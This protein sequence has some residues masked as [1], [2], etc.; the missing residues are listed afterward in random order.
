M[1]YADRSDYQKELLNELYDRALGGTYYLLDHEGTLGLAA[2][3]LL[4][5]GFIER[6]T[7]SDQVVGDRTFAAIRLNTYGVQYMRL[8]REG[9]GE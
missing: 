2:V 6:L 9:G 3:L 5:E 1:R 8:I 4:K 7:E